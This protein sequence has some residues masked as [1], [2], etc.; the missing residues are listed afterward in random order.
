MADW[1]TLETKTAYE[2][3]W[4]RIREDSVVNPAGQDGIYGVVELQHDSSYAVP[5][6][7]NGKFVLTRQFRYPLQRDTWEFP[8]GQN[9]GQDPVEA[10][11]REM[12]EETGYESS[13]LT[14][15]T[16]LGADTGLSSSYIDII[17]AQNA[18]H[19]TNDLDERDGIKE[20][21]AFT[22]SEMRSMILAGDIIC[23]HTIASFYIATEHLKE[24]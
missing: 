11:K 16:S 23:P 17:L 9:D 21:K 13:Q 22:S 4:I 24:N 1:Q 2:N 8:S 20:V 18:Q 19:M 14:K 6:T 12:L 15:V 10:A 5:V 7:P 3:N